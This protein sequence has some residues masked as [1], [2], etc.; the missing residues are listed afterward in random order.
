MQNLKKYL[1][2]R[3]VSFLLCMV[4]GIIAIERPSEERATFFSL[5][6]S[7]LFSIVLILLVTKY[8]LGK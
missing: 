4:I 5:I 7:L 6:Q 3:L 2:Y 8:F 1:T